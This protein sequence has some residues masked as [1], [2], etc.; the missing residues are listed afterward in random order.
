M[1]EII[2]KVIGILIF[3]KAIEP[4]IH[5]LIGLVQE[6]QGFFGHPAAGQSCIKLA[7]VKLEE[8]IKKSKEQ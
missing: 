6:N 3:Y 1:T 7:T 8:L 5:K 2:D 4:D